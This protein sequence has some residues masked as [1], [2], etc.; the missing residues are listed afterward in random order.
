[1]R[2]AGCCAGAPATGRSCGRCSRRPTANHPRREARRRTPC[3]ARTPSPERPS[4]KIRGARVRTAGTRPSWGWSLPATTRRRRTRP[5]RT[6]RRR[7]RPRARHDTWAAASRASTGSRRWRVEPSSVRTRRRTVRSGCRSCGPPTRT[8]ASRSATAPRCTHAIRDWPASSPPPTCRASTASASTPTS[9][10]S[11]C[12]RPASPA[13]AAR[14]WRRWS[15]TATPSIGSPTTRSPS[16]GSRCRH[17]TTR[18]R[19]SPRGRRRSSRPIRTT[20]SPGGACMPGRC[21]RPAATS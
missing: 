9:R 16:T 2:S 15:G 19:R 7:T 17:S 12:S 4:R 18:A 8:P 14:R 11:R 1:M 13:T 5:G 20:C 6:W 3:A 10:T 21:R